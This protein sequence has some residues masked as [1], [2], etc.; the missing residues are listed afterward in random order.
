[1][2]GKP[3]SLMAGLKDVSRRSKGGKVTQR[4]AISVQILDDGW[5]DPTLKEQVE[6]AATAIAKSLGDSLHAGLRPDGTTMP[7]IAPA[8][9]ES[10]R[11]IVDAFPHTKSRAIRS[12]FRAPRLGTFRPETGGP[13]GVF[14]GML[15]SSFSA[16]ADRDGKGFTVYVASKRGQ[17]EPGDTLSAIQRVYRNTPLWSPSAME[18]IKGALKAA[19]GALISKDA[20]RFAR[21]IRETTQ[22]LQDIDEA[23]ED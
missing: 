22:T 4:T 5:F 15:A 14:S 6:A 16:R 3:I 8:T 17:P 12:E 19:F 9:V 20:R 2:A 7:P 18:R 1:M 13:R 23:A 21:A 11:R 10:R